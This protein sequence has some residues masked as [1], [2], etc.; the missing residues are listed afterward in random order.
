ML[1]DNRLAECGARV[2]AVLWVQSFVRDPMR[3]AILYNLALSMRGLEDG[4]CGPCAHPSDLNTS[5][6]GATDW[7]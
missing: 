6:D 4:I 7:G 5:V 3:R 1:Q 2:A